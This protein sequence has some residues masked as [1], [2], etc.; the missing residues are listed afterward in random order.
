[1]MPKV[2]VINF[3]MRYLRV[4]FIEYM[5][6]LNNNTS[7][8]NNFIIDSNMAQLEELEILCLHSRQKNINLSIQGDF[9]FE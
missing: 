6:E 7:K 9:K 2:C 1:M 3:P 5:D 8:K 4:L